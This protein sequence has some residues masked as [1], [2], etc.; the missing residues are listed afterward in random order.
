[1][2]RKSFAALLFAATISTAL[3][4]EPYV[5]GMGEIMGATQM[6]HSK[7]WF[8]GNAG[9]WPLADYELGE[10]REGL[11]DAVLYHPVFKEGIPVSKI[12]E[13]FTASP[14]KALEKAIGEKNKNDF[15]KAFDSLTDACNGC[16]HAANR[17]YI[18]IRRPIVSPYTNLDFSVKPR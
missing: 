7:L 12:L 18:V 16:H 11:D 17:S 15:R 2:N 13:R 3:A 5:P 4:A 14:L 8:A 1:M 9:N 10:I 6:R